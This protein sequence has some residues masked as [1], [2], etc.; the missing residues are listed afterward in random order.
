MPTAIIT[1]ASQGF[2]RALA[3]DLAAMDWSLV[4]DARRP[5]P[6]EELSHQLT[7]SG[8]AVR[9]LVGDV[10]DERHRDKLVENALALGDL[11]LLVNNASTLGPSPLPGLDQLELS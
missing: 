2:G 7:H 5:A 8:A 11:E 10:T 4:I 9:T 6:L 1:G 3:R